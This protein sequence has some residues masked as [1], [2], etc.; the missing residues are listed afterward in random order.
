MEVMQKQLTNSFHKKRGKNSIRIWQYF[1]SDLWYNETGKHNRVKK[2][3]R[4]KPTVNT[5]KLHRK[6]FEEWFL[7]RVISL[8]FNKNVNQI[9][10]WE[11][12]MFY[13]HCF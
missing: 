8:N 5:G 1:S 7:S 4:S 2:I 12:Q 9:K 11:K 3:N 6:N 13:Y 10:I